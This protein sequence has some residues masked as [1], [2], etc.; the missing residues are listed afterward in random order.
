MSDKLIRRSLP[1][2]G[3][4]LLKPRKC[5]TNADNILTTEKAPIHKQ[6]SS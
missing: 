6:D 5:L 2:G 1:F 4:N 3:G